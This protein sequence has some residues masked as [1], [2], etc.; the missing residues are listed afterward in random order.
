MKLDHSIGPRRHLTTAAAIGVLVLAFIWGCG[1]PK[2]PLS[3]AAQAFK[4]EVK[5]TLARLSEALAA[6]LAASDLPAAKEALKHIEPEASKLCR[7][8]PFRIGLLDKTGETLTVYPFKADSALD[9][10][11]YEVVLQAIRTRKAVQHR[12]YMQDG[13]LFYI[14][15]Q[16]LLRGGEVMG[17]VA[18]GLNAQ[19]AKAR[20]GI[21]EAEFLGIDFNI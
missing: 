21:T 18:L 1:S 15:C 17:I 4:E 16:P 11:N 20:W 9:F 6:P 14:I 8:C 13:S 19:E 5:T 2:P 10:S 12:L 3:P 7:M